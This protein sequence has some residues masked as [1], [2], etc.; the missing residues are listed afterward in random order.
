M[1]NTKRVG[2]LFDR[3]SLWLPRLCFV[4]RPCRLTDSD[5]MSAFFLRHSRAKTFAGCSNPLSKS[6]SFTPFPLYIITHVLYFGKI[7]K[8]LDRK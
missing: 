6:H 8:T 4:F 2:Y 3:L 7:K 5:A 1:A